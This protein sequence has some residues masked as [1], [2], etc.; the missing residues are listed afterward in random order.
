M[1]LL[2]KFS[3]LTLFVALNL[4]S[5]QAEEVRKAKSKYIEQ[6]QKVLVLQDAH[7]EQIAGK[8]PFSYR[9]R[10]IAQGG[11][12]KVYEVIITPPNGAA[13]GEFSTIAKILTKVKAGDFGNPSIQ[14]LIMNAQLLSKSPYFLGVLGLLN[15]KPA[16]SSANQGMDSEHPVIL[17]EK[18]LEDLD[19]LFVK[20]DGT[21][22]RLRFIN[23][24]PNDEISVATGQVLKDYSVPKLLK[25]MA[26]GIAF[27]HKNNLAHLDLKPQNMLMGVD[28]IV[29]IIDTDDAIE[30]SG[31]TTQAPG[32]SF[33]VPYTPPE[34]AR[35][36][37]EEAGITKKGF[38]E[39]F[40]KS[41]AID[42]RKADIYALGLSMLSI[43]TGLNPVKLILWALNCFE[44]PDQTLTKV[45]L[46]AGD[47]KCGST[48][49]SDLFPLI[50]KE[51]LN[52]TL[53]KRQVPGTDDFKPLY[54]LLV[55]M[56][57]ADPA[58]RPSIEE[59]QAELNKI[60]P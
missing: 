5:T 50:A 57:T 20:Q 7:Q 58:K 45:G 2:L 8:L 13:I 24:S 19:E 6:L 31:P 4:F 28:S 34:R 41:P 40:K 10:Y 37:L 1:K 54:D 3:V 56:L 51:T 53:A 15:N 22:R 33:S 36:I 48:Q 30:M 42:W 14:K 32:G 49:Y 17:I 11:F 27:M 44:N 18:G 26:G 47:N 52:D 43:V 12:G 60:Y 59:V 9:V 23:A 35:S 55:K 16:T 21:R 46:S 29:K 38:F 39:S 25:E